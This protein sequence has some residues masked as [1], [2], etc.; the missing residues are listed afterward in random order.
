MIVNHVSCNCDD[1]VDGGDDDTWPV[2]NKTE[3]ETESGVDNISNNSSKWL[4]W[5]WLC[6]NDDI[7]LMINWE[8]WRLW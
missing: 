3:T 5:E 2:F 7:M 8:W 6:Y 4:R 1:D